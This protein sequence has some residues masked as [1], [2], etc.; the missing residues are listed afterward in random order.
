MLNL[1]VRNT[2]K[3]IR[4]K[5]KSE[6]IRI[7]RFF[8]KKETARLMANML[9]LDENKT[10]YTVLD[11]GAGT[12][13]LSAAVV[14]EICNRCKNC[15]QI[16]LTCYENNPDFIPMLQDNLERI[17]KK[18]RHDY[19]VRVY[20]TVYE[21]N[22]ITESQNHYTVTFF[23]VIEDKFDIIICNPP[24]EF[25][26]KSTVEA[27]RAGGVTQV[28]I[29]AAYLFAKMAGKHLEDGGRLVI[30]LPTSVASASALTAY[31]R[32][33]AENLALDK[34][35]LFIGKQKN[36]KRAI[37]L[38]KSIILSYGKCP[39][40]LTV[41]VTTSTD[42][43][44]P[45]NTVMLPAL[46]YNFVVNEK[47]GSLTLPKSVEDT[48]IVQYISAFPDTLSSIGLKISTGLVIDSRCDGLLFTDPIKGC[49]P[50]IRPTAIKGGQ[51]KFPLPIK[52]QYLAPVN[53]SLI[54]K[55]KN[56]VII[57]RVPAKS[58][59]R[60]V[61][62]AIYMASQLPQH[63]FISTH[64]KIN[65]IDTKDKNE[66]MN[67]RLVFGLFALLNS[68]IYDRYLSIVSKSKQINAKELRDLPL[69]PKNLI[70]SLGVRL[71]SLRQASVDAC[72]SIVNPALHIKSK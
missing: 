65:F 18:A 23:D 19:D 25:V 48:K 34:I 59:D 67:A 43:G 42:W 50:L 11:P 9:T 60:F 35:H 38:K 31:R 53:P 1:A 54:Q 49:V 6:N 12:G 33:M 32:E 71:I 21:E 44:K 10:A 36:N 4:A 40:P 5:S 64:N 22:Y 47:D 68:T 26:E 37:P 28:K 56:M 58:D 30:M 3:L 70:E 27:K 13:I 7:G 8:T 45:E 14:E 17:R 29:S 15:R 2:S 39:K 46:D 16:F 69:P 63:K 55:N 57:K 72:D 62:A 66:E 24:T 51:I 52:H 41:T 61:N 20:V